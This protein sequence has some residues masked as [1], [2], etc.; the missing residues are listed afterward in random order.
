M[1]DDENNLV[2]LRFD[3]SLAAIASHHLIGARCRTTMPSRGRTA[4][5]QSLQKIEFPPEFAP[6]IKLRLV[7]LPQTSQD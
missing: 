1:A 4:L 7:S 5:E 2:Q 3:N 6:A